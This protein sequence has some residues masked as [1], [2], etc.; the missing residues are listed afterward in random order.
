MQVNVSARHG[1]LKNEDQTIIVE[2]A[3]KLRRFLSQIT[4]IEVTVD[5]GN[6]DKPHVEINI[7]AEHANDF[8]AHAESSTV[9]SA[10]DMSLQKAEQQLRKHKEKIT[11]HKGAG[12]KHIDP[13]IDDE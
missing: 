1:H 7:S 12:H 10:L 3:E 9:I 5:L 2:K 11:G 13:V 4:A 8:V 6:I